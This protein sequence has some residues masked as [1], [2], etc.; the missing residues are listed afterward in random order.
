MFS[1]KVWSTHDK[2][3][4]TPELLRLGGVGFKSATKFSIQGA[5]IAALNVKKKSSK[6]GLFKVLCHF[7]G[8]L[9][10]YLVGF[11]LNTCIT[12]KKTMKPG[13]VY[14]CI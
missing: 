6:V 5:K 9:K 4:L 7:F 11:F 2:S 13:L 12:E 3:Q 8:D 1:I 14:V 10:K